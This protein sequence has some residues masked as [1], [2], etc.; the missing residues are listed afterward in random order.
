VERFRIQANRHSFVIDF[1]D[2][3]P[4]ILGDEDRL[5]QVLNNLISNAIKY[6]PEGGE[7]CVQG[8]VQP[9]NIVICV[10]DQ[11]PGVAPEDMPHVFDRFYRSQSAARNTK[12]AG[13]G[14]FLARAVI[15]AHK[16]HIW[17]DPNP[18]I[19]AKFCFSL[20]RS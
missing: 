20:P 12:G 3:Y 5:E 13:L 19:G 14:L 8:T 2:N 6:S 16:G 18:A 17:L 7:I 11:G 9:Q 15:E 4:V 10:S 1:P